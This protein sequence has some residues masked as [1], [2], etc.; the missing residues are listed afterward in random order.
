MHGHTNNTGSPSCDMSVDRWEAGARNLPH[1]H[2]GTG[3]RLVFSKPFQGGGGGQSG[4]KCSQ[5][6]L[7]PVI[8]SSRVRGPH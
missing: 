1:R 3:E 8:G 5:I 2:S 7:Q 4:S 6:R